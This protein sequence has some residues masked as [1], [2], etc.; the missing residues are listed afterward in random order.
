MPILPS[1]ITPMLRMSFIGAS[2]CCALILDAFHGR[3][4][5]QP[6]APLR[7]GFLAGFF[8]LARDRAAG[9]DLPR[10]IPVAEAIAIPCRLRSLPRQAE[11]VPDSSGTLHE[12]ALRQSQRRRNILERGVDQ[13]GRFLA[14]RP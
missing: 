5:R 13:H 3:L 1:P 8:P 4:R 2:I 11:L 12:F 10:R 6:A 9:V 7:E 14:A